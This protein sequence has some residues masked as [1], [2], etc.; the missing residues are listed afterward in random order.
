MSFDVVLRD[1]SAPAAAHVAAT[2]LATAFPISATPLPDNV[3][4]ALIAALELPPPPSASKRPPRLDRSISD[5][6]VVS[7]SAPEVRSIRANV[8]VEL[9]GVS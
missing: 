6:S 7:K 9:K 1:A 2:H 4:A 3:P 5:A 8:G